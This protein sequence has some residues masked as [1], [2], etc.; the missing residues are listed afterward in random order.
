MANVEESEKIPAIPLQVIGKDVNCKIP[1]TVSMVGLGCSSFSSFFWTN[2]ER[3]DAT[4]DVDFLERNNNN[5]YVEEWIETIIYSIEQ[6]GITLLDT[7]PWYGHGTSERV[8]GWAIKELSERKNFC[9]SNIMINTKVGRYEADP[10]IQFD[11]SR[12]TT[13][14]SVERSIQRM[15]CGY[16]NVLQL[17]DPEFSPSLDLLM[18]ETI[19]AML[20][21]QEKGYCKALGMT[22]KI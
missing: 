2:D 21:C 16:I 4:L 11:F 7:A 12:T 9:R 8:I 10:S 1:S 6:A 3:G 18:V 19:P 15:N 14:R 22:G 13:I 5:T 17:H 20:E